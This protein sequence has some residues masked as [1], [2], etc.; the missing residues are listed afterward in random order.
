VGLEPSSPLPGGLFDFTQAAHDV[1]AIA[2]TLPK[3]V[4]LVGTSLGGKVAL[5]A[6]AM[7][8]TNADKLVMLC[9]SA[10][11]TERS[12][13]VYRWFEILCSEIDGKHLGDL[14]APF[15]FGETFLNEKPGV[16]DNII[17]STK[18]SAESRAFMQAQ[19]RAL[20]AFDGA[21]LCPRVSVPTLCLAGAED[22]LTLPNEVKQTAALI[23]G[24]EHQ[25]FDNAGH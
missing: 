14:T 1:L 23:P 2:A 22:T 8:N 9:S 5:C 6:A 4:T 19:A 16:V 18:P 15:L 21:A 7:E 25:C 11:Q 20:Q 10:L 3:P 17:R 13:R 24:A 12:K